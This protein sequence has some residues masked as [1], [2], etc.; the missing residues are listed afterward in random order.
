MGYMWGSMGGGFSLK[1]GHCVCFRGPW[2]AKEARIENGWRNPCS[3]RKKKN[4]ILGLEGD[5][6]VV[7]QIKPSSSS[8]VG[9]LPAFQLRYNVLGI[10]FPPA[11]ENRCEP[12]GVR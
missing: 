1:G 11:F 5:L 8:P 10:I 7:V 9:L 2:K 6:G 3:D 12:T 4:Q